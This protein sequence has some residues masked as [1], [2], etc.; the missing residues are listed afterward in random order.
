L[1]NHYESL[2][3]KK[4]KKGGG[5]TQGDVGRLNVVPHNRDGRNDVT[6][7]NE[8]DSPIPVIPPNADAKGAKERTHRR[9]W[10]GAD[11]DSFGRR[12][13]NKRKGP[14]RHIVLGDGWGG[15]NDLS[16][17]TARYT[18]RTEGP[19]REKLHRARGDPMNEVS[20]LRREGLNPQRKDP[21]RPFAF[22]RKRVV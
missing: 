20:R 19:Y 4:E 22:R 7:K 16:Q 9:D 3:K 17:P 14:G 1:E 18:R 21:T 8:Q 15:K 2:V 6:G 11:T 13:L 5:G 12:A 10:Q